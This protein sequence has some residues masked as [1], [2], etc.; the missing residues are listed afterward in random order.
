[1]K[2]QNF[3]QGAFIAT[4]GIVLSKILGILYVIPFYAIIGDQGGALYGYAYSIYAIFLGISTAGVPLAMSKIISEYNA[5]G[6]Y[7]L[8]ERA[9]KLGEKV[10]NGIGILCFI[11]LMIFA[12]PI[13]YL[14]IGNVT[15]GNTIN[16]IALVIRLISASI[17]IVPILSVYRGYLQG[18]RFFAPTS[19]SQ[20]LEQIV[21]VT[22]IIVGSFLCMKIFN[23]SL[24]TTVGIAVF[25]AFPASLISWLYLRKKIKNNKKQLSEKTLYVEEPKITDKEIIKQIITYAIPFVMID[26]FRTL[27]NSVDVMMLVKVLV[28]GLGYTTAMAEGVMGIVSTWGNKLNM[29][30]IAVGTGVISSLIPNISSSFVKGD[31]KD[32]NEKINKTL[33]VILF[34]TLP[35]VVGL[36]ILAKPVWMIF[37]GASSYGPSV[38][39]YFVFVAL[40]TLLFTSTITIVQMMKDYKIVFITLIIGFLTNVICNIP[41]LYAFDAMG[42]PAYYGSIT[43]TIC[44]YM[45]AS[46]ISLVYLNKKHHINYEE[47]ARR[48]IPTFM[49]L[50]SMI[51]V[52]LLLNIILPFNNLTRFNSIIYVIIYAVI[53]AIVYFFVSAKTK[54]LYEIFGKDIVTN[55][56]AKFKRKKKKRG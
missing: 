4:L 53:G 2:K 46:I 11:V 10:L 38:Y 40:A 21:R 47:T 36:S 42:L 27:Y 24:T 48:L 17:L 16:D 54:V 8:K 41:F 44:G 19:I 28:N 33:Q 35:M 34:I 32:V 43:S 45:V 5:L 37:Y 30:V 15:G 55:I 29:I 51:I 31:M 49:S 18:H 1:M 39:C 6:Y 25:A 7:S 13:A 52:L 56:T 50:F 22:I 26:I 20:V 9:F 12:K 23:L 14:I 3:M